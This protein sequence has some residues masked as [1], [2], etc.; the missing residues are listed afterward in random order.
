MRK[1]AL[2]AILVILLVGLVVNVVEAGDPGNGKGKAK[3]HKKNHKADTE[4]SNSDN[5]NTDSDSVHLGNGNTGSTKTR[6]GLNDTKQN[7]NIYSTGDTL[8]YHANKLHEGEY[9]VI[10]KKPGKN[11]DTVYNQSVSVGLDGKVDIEL[12]SIPEG[13]QGVYQVQICGDKHCKNDNI[14]VKNEGNNAN[15]IIPSQEQ[16]FDNVPPADLPSRYW[17]STTDLG[18]TDCATIVYHPSDVKVT[19]V[20]FFRPEHANEPWLHESEILGESRVNDDGVV[21]AHF[22]TGERFVV[23]EYNEMTGIYDYRA[24]GHVI[25]SYDKL[26]DVWS[27]GNEVSILF[28][29]LVWSPVGAK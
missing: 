11:G 9:T 12:T 15:N 10:V 6:K 25:G 26:I 13:W 27:E 8:S 3:G 20:E 19:V 18:E 1:L 24:M 28:N 29:T 14:N 17:F 22:A 5:S 7:Q 16:H 21:I 2:V 23:F 4:Q